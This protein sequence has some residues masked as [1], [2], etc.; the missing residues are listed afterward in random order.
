MFLSNIRLLRCRSYRDPHS[1]LASVKKHR[2]L[3]LK[4]LSKNI[5][6]T[7]INIE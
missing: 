6:G 1:D 3:I 4:Y 5:E 7:Y 2:S